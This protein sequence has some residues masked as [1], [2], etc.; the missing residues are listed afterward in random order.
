M[1]ESNTAERV[2]FLE[3]ARRCATKVGK[4]ATVLSLISIV[5]GTVVGKFYDDAPCSQSA[6]IHAL[7]SITAVCVIGALG[8]SVIA[9]LLGL[10]TLRLR[11]ITL[12]LMPIIIFLGWMSISLRTH[13]GRTKDMFAVAQL[14]SISA[15]EV[16]H[17]G[18]A[19]KY[20]SIEDLM[21][22]GLLDT[23][24]RATVSDYKFTI[25]AEEEEYTAK[26]ASASDH[27][28]WDYF[29]TADAIVR[30]S[31][32]PARAPKGWAGQSAQ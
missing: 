13:A 17:Y 24:F 30:Y 15:A 27:G 23:R 16:T 25:A 31:T 11:P 5:L 14:R 22:D 1:S 6:L 9:V 32:D 21:R 18:H 3:E 8:L 4:I 19:N 26:A 7:E 20:G 28:C 29:T 2:G 12:G 10:I